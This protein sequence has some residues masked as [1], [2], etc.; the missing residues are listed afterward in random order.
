M[1]IVTEYTC[2]FTRKVVSYSTKSVGPDQ[3]VN[4]KQTFS[5]AVILLAF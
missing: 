2:K 4:N 5:D 3:T 1:N